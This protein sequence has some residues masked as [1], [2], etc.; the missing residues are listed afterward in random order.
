MTISEIPAAIATCAF[1]I[2]MI[3]LAVFPF[4]W[5]L[6]FLWWKV[7]WK[8]KNITNILEKFALNKNG[9]YSAA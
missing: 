1:Y 7:F 4:R 8:K 2:M 6:L 5:C 9:H 3:F